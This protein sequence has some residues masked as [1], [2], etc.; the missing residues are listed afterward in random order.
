M[1][2]ITAGLVTDKGEEMETE[3]FIPG[4]INRKKFFSSLGTGLF[5]YFVIKSIPFSFL[6]R[7]V[8]DKNVTIEIN[9]DAVRRTKIGDKN[10]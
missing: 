9:P 3:K 8:K 6:G 1:V 10:V 4:N 5:G 7:N 2:R